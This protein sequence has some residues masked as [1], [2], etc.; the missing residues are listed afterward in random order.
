MFTDKTREANKG[1]LDVSDIKFKCSENV[2]LK[3]L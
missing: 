2:L 1:L 3:I